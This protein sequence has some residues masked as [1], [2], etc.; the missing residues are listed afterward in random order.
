MG[1]TRVRARACFCPRCHCGHVSPEKRANK[2]GE[3]EAFSSKLQ[4]PAIASMT[5][6]YEATCCHLTGHEL[7]NRY[8]Q[9]RVQLH[10]DEGLG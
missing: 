1:G 5:H 7:G 6:H 2:A 10:I 9:L 4:T 8:N 3:E